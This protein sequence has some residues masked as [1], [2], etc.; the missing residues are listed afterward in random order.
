LWISWRGYC[1]PSGVVR[2]HPLKFLK[3]AELTGELALGERAGSGTKA[4]TSVE[5]FNIFAFFEGRI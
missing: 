3:G 5:F 1:S 2:E 4:K